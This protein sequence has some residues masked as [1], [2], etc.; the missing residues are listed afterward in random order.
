VGF[1]GDEPI[2]TSDVATDEE[3]KVGNVW[4]SDHLGVWVSVNLDHTILAESAAQ[5]GLKVSRFETKIYSLNLIYDVG[6]KPGSRR[7]A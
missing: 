5:P 7:S 3:G 1:L 2:R 6:N 4:A